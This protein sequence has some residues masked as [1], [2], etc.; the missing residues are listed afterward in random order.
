MDSWQ[1]K[2]EAA[3][4]AASAKAKDVSAA[5]S[6]KTKAF[7]ACAVAAKTC[8]VHYLSILPRSQLSIGIILSPTRTNTY[9]GRINSNGACILI[10]TGVWRRLKLQGRP[11]RSLMT[12][13]RIR[14]TSLACPSDSSSGHPS[15]LARDWATKSC[16]A[17]RYHSEQQSLAL[18]RDHGNES[19]QH[20]A[21]SVVHVHE[22]AGVR[23]R[24]CL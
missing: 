1:A 22:R 15:V 7:T 3:A 20:T 8:S 11:R 23:T 9:S 5:A 17:T 12:Y 4:A 13:L 24:E 14:R 16:V 10:I 18:A 21:P 2:A 6:V 19:P